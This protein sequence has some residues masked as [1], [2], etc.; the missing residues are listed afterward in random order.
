MYSEATA[1]NV[2]LVALVFHRVNALVELTLAIDNFCS[3]PLQSDDIKLAKG[4]FRDAARGGLGV[5]ENEP[6][7][8]AIRRHKEVE[9]GA[10]PVPPRLGGSAL[11]VGPVSHV[12]FLQSGRSAYDPTYI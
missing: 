6:P 7:T 8:L 1:A 9:V 11:L 12:S 3:R 4:G 10:H 5:A 2:T